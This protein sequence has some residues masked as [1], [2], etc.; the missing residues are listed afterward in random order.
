MK[1][2]S[3]PRKTVKF[4]VL[5]SEEG[6]TNMSLCPTFWERV[7][8]KQASKVI[9]HIIDDLKKEIRQQ[10]PFVIAPILWSVEVDM[11]MFYGNTYVYV[12]NFERKTD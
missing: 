11:P 10:G 7:A 5:R 1:M 8:M 3:V 4:T 9:A 12:N 6:V 2:L